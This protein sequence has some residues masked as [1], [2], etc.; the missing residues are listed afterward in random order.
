[1]P[2]GQTAETRELRIT[3]QQGVA[4]IVFLRAA[5]RGWGII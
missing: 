4:L 2:F 1:M 5:V 3:G